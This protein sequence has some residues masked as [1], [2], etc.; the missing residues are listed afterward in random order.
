MEW[1]TRLLGDR[2]IP[3]VAEGNTHT[4]EGWVNVHCPYCGDDNYH[5]GINTESGGCHCWR[6]G[7][8]PMIATFSQLL[9]LSPSQT[10]AV[11]SEYRG[12]RRVAPRKTTARPH[13]E[14]P[15]KF[16]TPNEPLTRP[17][18]HYLRRRH[19]DPEQI[20]QEWGVRQ[21]GPMSKLDGVSYS[22][23]L[24]IPVIWDGQV[25]SF[26]ARDIT[27]RAHMRYMACPRQR[28]RIHHK[29]ILYG[30]QE[31]WDAA[32]QMIVVEGVT[33]VWRL[34]PFA[35]AV[36]GIEFRMEQ[37]LAMARLA[38]QFFIAFDDEPTAQEQAER[39]AVRL[40]VLGKRT[41]ICPPPGKDPGGMSQ[42]DADHF[43]RQ[44]IR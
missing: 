6:C 28:E 42:D 26:Q 1:V 40:R 4:T 43:V 23:R 39:L 41:A 36:F 38:D 35:A 16:P 24:L 37:V 19:F 5:L 44:L 29:D 32:R 33:D 31:A 11:I 2:R 27:G 30:K 25:V 8:H 22:Y 3:Y 15:F 9:R 10:W 12:V 7:T 14:K 18:I 20:V 17:Y 34:G 13:G 21:T